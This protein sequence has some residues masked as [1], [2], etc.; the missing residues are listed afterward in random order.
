MGQN[1]MSHQRCCRMDFSVSRGSCFH[2]LCSQ[3]LLLQKK[4]KKSHRRKKAETKDL[5]WRLWASQP[6]DCL[7]N[8]VRI[9]NACSIID[10]GVSHN[11]EAAKGF[12]ASASWQ[13]LGK[14]QYEP[15]E[16]EGLDKL[17]PRAQTIYTDCLL[18]QRLWT[19]YSLMP[20]NL[21]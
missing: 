4:K 13:K 1:W 15:L 5:K 10:K 21:I 19:L 18:I 12:G 3:F 9:W 6:Y 11:K 20:A 16:T 14:A 17:T 8:E 7:H 2:S